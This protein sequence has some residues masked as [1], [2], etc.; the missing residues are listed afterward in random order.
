[1]ETKEK[2]QKAI[3]EQLLMLPK[4]SQEV[5][6]SFPWFELISEMKEKHNF[7]DEEIIQ[8]QTEVA[9]LL[10]GLTPPEDFTYNLANEV[11]F[12]KTEVPVIE[13]EILE[14][15]LQPIAAEIEGKVKTTSKEKNSSIDQNINFN[16]SGGNYIY[17][18]DSLGKK[19]AEDST[20]T[21]KIP[22]QKTDLRSHFTI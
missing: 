7:T 16:L 6:R 11:G 2:L 8:L 20:P 4:E 12:T 15:I 19:I 5:L 22:T 13:K 14:K 17:L 18:T 1:M 9:L 3:E 21:P 10:V